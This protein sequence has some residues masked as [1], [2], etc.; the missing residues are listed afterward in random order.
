[1]ASGPRRAV[2]RLTG[3]GRVVATKF[4]PGAFH[5]FH[6]ANHAIA[7]GSGWFPW[8]RFFGPDAKVAGKPLSWPAEDDTQAI[9]LLEALLRS[10]APKFDAKLGGWL[11]ELVD[12]VR[13]RREIARAD[14]F[15]AKRQACPCA[16][17]TGCS[18]ATSASVPSG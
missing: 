2:V 9:A 11:I 17:C 6:R 5:S 15:G 18:G 3:R 12:R 16:R 10:R 13:E 8:R 14:D 4:K 7:A 1:M